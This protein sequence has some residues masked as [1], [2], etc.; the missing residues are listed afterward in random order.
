MLFEVCLV[1]VLA[2]S[3]WQ[4]LVC[5]YRSMYARALR[6]LRSGHAISLQ[7]SSRDNSDRTEGASAALIL[8]GRFFPQQFRKGYRRKGRTAHYVMRPSLSAG[9]ELLDSKI[10]CYRLCI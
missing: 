3:R 8:H 4:D 7:W 6:T 1:L 9:S 10:A 2:P 5:R